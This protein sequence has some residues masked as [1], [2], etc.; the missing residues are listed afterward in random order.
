[1]PPP[2]LVCLDHARRRLAVR[3]GANGIDYVRP[4]AD[5][6]TLI[7]GLLQPWA[8]AADALAAA[9]G[10]PARAGGVEKTFGVRVGVTGGRAGTV[11]VVRAVSPRNDAEGYGLLAVVLTA[12]AD[13][14][15]DYTVTLSDPGDPTGQTRPPGFDKQLCGVTFQLPGPPSAAGP[16]CGPQPCPPAAAVPGP[17]IDYLAKDYASFRRLMFDRLAQTLPD[18]TEQRAADLGVTVIEALAYAADH[19][20]YFQDAVATEAYLK[21]ARRRIS[22]RRHARLVDYRMHDGCN[23]RTWVFVEVTQPVAVGDWM[24][25]TNPTTTCKTG[26]PPVSTTTQLTGPTEA[27]RVV[28]EPLQKARP[29]GTPRQLVPQQNAIPFFTWGESECCLPAGATSAALDADPPDGSTSFGAWQKDGPKDLPHVAK[30][31]AWSDATVLPRVGDLLLFE[32]QIGARTGLPADADRTHRQVVRLTQVAKQFDSR[33]VVGATLT[34]QDYPYLAIGWAAEDALSF[35]VC[36]SA[37][38]YQDVSVARGNIVLV[39]QGLTVSQATTGQT[40]TYTLTDP[41]QVA[42]TPGSQLRLVTPVVPPAAAADPCAASHALLGNP[43]PVATP[44]RTTVARF[45]PPFQRPLTQ[46]APFPDRSTQAQSQ[47]RWLARQP[48]ASADAI[49]SARGGM[50]VSAAGTGGGAATAAVGSILGPASTDLTPDI[51]AARTRLCL[52]EMGPLSAKWEARCDLL[53]S[54]PEDR[55]F[56]IE[57]DDWGD[58]WLRFGDGDC[59]QQ[60]AAGSAFTVEYRVGNGTTGNIGAEALAGVVGTGAENVR[61]VRNPLPASGGTDPETT[62]DVRRLAPT[63]FRTDLIRA[64]A[65]ADYA[66]LAKQDGRVEQATAALA[67]TGTGYEVRVSVKLF[68]AATR[69]AA[70]PVAEA[71]LILEEIESDL[72]RYRRIGH[73]VNVIPPQE[74]PLVVGL[75]LW[76]APHADSGQVEAA[77]RAELGSGTLPDGRRGFFYPDDLTFGQSIWASAITTR[78]AAVPGVLAIQLRQL[79]RET[80]PVV[81]AAAAGVLTLGPL[82]V[83]RL[84]DDPAAPENGRLNLI[85]EGGR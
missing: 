31:W 26:R 1:M 20:S 11:P 56:V 50:V 3:A 39:D 18:W 35:P 21:T 47:A 44:R 15:T 83:A 36:I 32:E 55:H 37:G 66:Q 82:E 14:L 53:D 7:V 75:H 48:A 71:A 17:P 64:V 12:P 45:V 2:A 59:G 63:A 30:N 5:R 29:E 23:A 24:F 13:P 57:F 34:W 8:A 58:P 33:P 49:A 40:Q 60:P 78:A 52:I 69:W 42:S 51:R 67:W 70:D 77:V 10:D 9:G 46:A 65:A 85:S 22:V 68:A 61:Q 41:R 6:T 54:G 62:G 19:V 84:D 27:D 28:F 38:G 74:V 25:F 80:R 81:N 43:T 72:G 76:V 16:D 79:R 73:T 4:G